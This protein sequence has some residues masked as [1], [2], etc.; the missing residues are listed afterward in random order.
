M[1][2]LK[3]SIITFSKAQCSAWVASAA[4]FAVT[5]AL[6]NIFGMWYGYATFIG[7][8]SGGMV[9]CAINYRWVFHAFGMKKK[10][11]ALR[12]MFVWGVSIALNTLG[13]CQVTEMTGLNYVISSLPYLWLFCGTIRCSASSSFMKAEG[14]YR[15]QNNK[16]NKKEI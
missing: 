7:A 11:I 2:S 3:H 8:V 14:R 10:Y 16:T 5:L 1:G 13:T 12:Y 4:D 15:K 9:N 6:V